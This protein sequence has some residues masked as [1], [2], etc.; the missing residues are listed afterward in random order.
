M[1]AVVAIWYLLV[2]YTELGKVMAGPEEVF[3]L[4]CKYFIEPV[5]RTTLF[6]HIGASLGRVLIG[7]SIASLAGVTLG[8]AMGYSKTVRAIAAPLFNIVRPIPAVAWIPMTILW[9]GIG[10]AA[11][12]FIIFI[13]G[14]ANTVI[15]S[16]SGVRTVDP[17]L[18]GAAQ[19]L[20][21]SKWQTFRRVIL[22]SSFPYVFA[23]LQ[24]SLSGS[25]MSV[26]AAEMVSSHEGVGWLIITGMNNANTAQIM[27]GMIP[28][29]VVGFILVSLMRWI[30]KKLCAWND[31]SR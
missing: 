7:Y 22:P 14:F 30:E 27:A 29:G 12:I 10:E 20:G 28:I 2:K 11:K 18:I 13:G 31:R 17:V 19:L 4:I 6:G 21:A 23:G 9:L 25:W 3:A 24:I 5:G 15:N 1:I 16:M 8:L 26:L